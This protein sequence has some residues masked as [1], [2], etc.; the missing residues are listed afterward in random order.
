MPQMETVH[1][2]LGALAKAFETAARSAGAELRLGVPAIDLLV[3]KNVFGR[4]RAGGVLLA[5]GSRVEARAVLSTLDLQQSMFFW[6]RMPASLMARA[7]S[8]R[9]AGRAGRLLL[10]LN[11]PVGENAFILPGNSEAAAAWRDGR[12]PALPA[13][14]FNPVSVRDPS[15]APEG[16]ATATVTVDNVPTRLQDGAWTH[17]R[18]V[19]FASQ[20]LARLT[21]H[22]PALLT[23]LK[24]VD[25]ILPADMEAELGI[26]E[27]DL[28]GGSVN[29]KEDRPGPRTALPRFYL[30]GPS[31]Q[32]S[33]LGTGAS[34]LAAA[35]A[36]LAD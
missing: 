20:V 12:L 17:R 35:I 7:R 25:I 32:A 4:A 10:A 9:F 11:R 15:L 28:E 2:G 6:R 34:G 26:T 31:T 30:G 36:M 5:D 27:G 18:R 21:Q 33:T 19:E 3:D 16:A 14:T 24:A 8:F 29:D 13:L 22:Q 23:A 1:G